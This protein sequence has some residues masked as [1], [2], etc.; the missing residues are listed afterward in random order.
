MDRPGSPRGRATYDVSHFVSLRKRPS[1]DEAFCVRP[2]FKQYGVPVLV[3]ALL[4]L[5]LSPFTS[6]S[7][8]LDLA[9]LSSISSMIPHF[10]EALPVGADPAEDITSTGITVPAV[11]ELEVDVT[12]EVPAPVEPITAAVI[13]ADDP[14][15]DTFAPVS[16]TEPEVDAVSPDAHSNSFFPAGVADPVAEEAEFEAESEAAIEAEVEAEAEAEAD[17]EAQAD[18]PEPVKAKSMR[19]IRR[20]RR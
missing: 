14:T 5:V 10:G 2:D 6:G 13:P 9:G 15:P 20:T 7:T 16:V 17:M 19:K 11:D 3:P 12:P 18:D 1:A 4:C 8:D